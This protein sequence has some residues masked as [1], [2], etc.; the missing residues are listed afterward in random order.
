MNIIESLQWRYATKKF[1]NQKIL[2]QDKIDLISEAFNLT[3][4]SYGLQP[5]QLLII[6]DKKIQKELTEH[7]WNQ[8]QV[9]DASHLLVIC[10]ENKIDAKYITK[11]FE[12]VKSIRNTPSE[13]LKPFEEQLITSFTQKSKEEISIWATKQAYLAMGNLLTVCAIEKIDACPMEGFIPEKYDEILNLK[14]L[15]LTSVLVLPIG[16]RAE[17][18]MF[19]ELK[20]VR[21]GVQNMVVN[22]SS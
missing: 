15:G 18:D 11:Y 9:A 14:D 8:Q 3:A 21:R 16:Y 12:S 10:I 22:I 20:K 4:T 1:D 13:I 2:S 5:L 7:S 6:K 17:D 19:S